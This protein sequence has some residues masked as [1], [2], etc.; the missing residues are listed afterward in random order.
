MESKQFI[1]NFD[2]YLDEIYD[3]IKPELRPILNELREMDPHDLVPLNGRY[4]NNEEVRG[5][6][7]TLFIR[8]AL[9]NTFTNQS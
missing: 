4:Q 1:N 9:N 2:Y 5:R 6:I 3:V 8:K 7:W